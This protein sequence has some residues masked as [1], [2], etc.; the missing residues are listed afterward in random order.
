MSVICGS[1]RTYFFL[2][3]KEVEFA[4]PQ[5]T[6]KP[7]YSTHTLWV[8]PWQWRPQD[9]DKASAASIPLSSEQN[10]DCLSIKARSGPGTPVAT[11]RSC[12]A[13]SQG[14]AHRIKIF[15]AR[16]IPADLGPVEMAQAAWRSH[17]HRP[18]GGILSTVS[19]ALPEPS[20]PNL[21]QFCEGSYFLPG[22]SEHQNLDSRDHLVQKAIQMGSLTHKCPEDPHPHRGHP[23]D[24]GKAVCARVQHGFGD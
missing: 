7:T 12:G 13:H 16:P 15:H 22:A 14:N 18:Q 6:Y 23:E 3:I 4:C 9:T 21:G 1:D 17:L 2:R 24:C 19:P 5:V 8:V 11:R 20:P 10:R